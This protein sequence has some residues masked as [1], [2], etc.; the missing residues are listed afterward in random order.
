M[1]GQGELTSSRP[2]A[3]VRRPHGGVGTSMHLAEPVEN[4]YLT[5]KAWSPSDPASDP[6]VVWP[7]PSVVVPSWGNCVFLFVLLRLLGD[8][9]VYLWPELVPGRTAHL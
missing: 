8:C 6:G 5:I 3:G 4:I 7:W 9:T 2:P 1:H